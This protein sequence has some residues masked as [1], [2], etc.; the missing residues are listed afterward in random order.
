LRISKNVEIKNG[1]DMVE[2]EEEPEEEPEEAPEEEE[3]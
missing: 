1:E 3:W 2:W